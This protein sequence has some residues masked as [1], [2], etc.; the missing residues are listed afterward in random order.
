M[1]IYTYIY[2]CIH[3]YMYI[4]IFTCTYICIYIFTYTSTY[5]YLFMY[6][7]EVIEEEHRMWEKWKE[8]HQ[9][10]MPDLKIKQH[11]LFSMV[12]L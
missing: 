11:P 7:D 8:E 3:R 1:Y 4:Y 9:R 6:T 10:K 5:I 2:M 12:C